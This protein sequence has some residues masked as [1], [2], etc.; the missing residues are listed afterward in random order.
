M[1]LTFLHSRSSI[2]V[3]WLTST[4]LRGSSHK[5]NRIEEE[6]DVEEEGEKKQDED[7]AEEEEKEKQE[8]EQEQEPRG[9]QGAPGAPIGQK[10]LWR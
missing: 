2:A 4:I 1:K 8:E 7:Q 3:P 6:D 9:T 5:T 10:R